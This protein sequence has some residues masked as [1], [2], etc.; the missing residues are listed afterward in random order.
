MVQWVTFLKVLAILEMTGILRLIEEVSALGR[1]DAFI[2]QKPCANWW[3]HFWVD[4]QNCML[5]VVPSLEN[6]STTSMIPGSF[7]SFVSVVQN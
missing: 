1:P 3:L 6:N 2:L 5:T 7:L 4:Q